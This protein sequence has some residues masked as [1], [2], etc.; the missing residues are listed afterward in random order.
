MSTDE[1]RPEEAGFIFQGKAVPDKDR[2]SP[3]EGDAQNDAAAENTIRIHIDEVIH[4]TAELRGLRGSD[5]FLI[6]EHKATFEGGEEFVFFTDIVSLGN[7]L[8]VR[9]L[10]HRRATSQSREEISEALRIAAAR[11]LA[12]RVRQ[13]ELIVIGEVTSS[14]VLERPFPPRS[15][16]DPEW[17]VAKVAVRTVLKGKKPKGEV[18]VLFASSHDVA[19]YKSPKLHE[20]KHGIFLL[21]VTRDDDEE[22][23][24]PRDMARPIYK[25]I[26]PLDFQS[27]EREAEVRRLADEGGR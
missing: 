15:E 2:P 16:H 8:V 14:R 27:A 22:V 7:K 13:A 3:D 9:E 20:G 21:H 6:T 1:R 26:D 18:E 25:V 10:G 24:R 12:E 17:G 19:W 23:E 5:A 11:P 4:S